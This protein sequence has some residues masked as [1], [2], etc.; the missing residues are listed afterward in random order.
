MSNRF[1]KSE[2]RIEQI[3]K[4]SFEDTSR[5]IE[6]LLFY[7]SYLESNLKFPL[8]ITGIED[9]DW[10]EFYL[11]GPGEKEEYEILKKTRPSYTGIFK[12]TSFDSYYDEDYGLFAK[13]TR[14]SDKKR[15][16]LPLADMKALDKKSL[17]YQLLEDYSIWVI[18][19]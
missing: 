15:F 1:K 3:F 2:E 7:K 4:N 5:R 16:K 18:N 19:Y 17:E 10:E 12:M 11:L 14:I 9:F 6:T 13:V 8:D